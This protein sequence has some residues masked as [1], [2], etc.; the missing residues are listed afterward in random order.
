[1]ACVACM[2]CGLRGHFLNHTPVA[3]P[4]AGMLRTACWH[5]LP[6][7][8]VWLVWPAWLVWHGQMQEC[9]AFVCW[10]VWHVWHICGLRGL[11]DMYGMCGLLAYFLNYTL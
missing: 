11:R 5:V 3:W 1:V 8:P 9:G 7:W 2:D 10:H 6:A 4:D